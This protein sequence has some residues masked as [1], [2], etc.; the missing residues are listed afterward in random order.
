MFRRS[1][2]ASGLNGALSCVK[3]A[4]ILCATTNSGDVVTSTDPGGGARA[5]QATKVALLSV[6]CEGGRHQRDHHGQLPDRSFC[7]GVDMAGNVITSTDPAG[8]V[9]VTPAVRGR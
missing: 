2:A 3:A 4:P 1:I 9:P 7:A 5:W 8:G 6:D